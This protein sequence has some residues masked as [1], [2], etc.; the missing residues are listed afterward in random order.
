MK[1]PEP[2]VYPGIPFD[3]YARWDAANHSTLRHFKKT[4]A[5]VYWEMTH[6]DE[7][8]T[9]QALGHLIHFAVLE[10]ERFKAEGPVVAPNVDRRT[11]LGKA[12]W[13]EFQ[14]AHK[15]RAIVTE[16]DM[17]TLLGIQS[18]IAR[19]ATAREAL[20]GPGASELSLVWNDKQTGVLCKGRI[21]RVCEIGGWPMILDIKTTSKPASTH[22]FQIS[23]DTYEYHVQAALYLR[24]VDTLIPPDEGVVRKYGWLVCETE[25]PYCVR[26]F[27]AEE[28]ALDIG[29][30]TIDKYL[31]QMKVCK[32]KNSWPGW[33]EGMDNAGLPPWVYKR[34]DIE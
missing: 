29:R 1:A 26:M 30:E 4:A 33:P 19:H 31:A 3:D 27:E 34:Y 8:T 28:A 13:A 7:S 20:Y 5:H 12:T 22:T 23:I 9:F 15:G 2:G 11:T 32:E 24:G 6:Q 25:A 10:P 14:E 18:N 16:K 21:D 17:E